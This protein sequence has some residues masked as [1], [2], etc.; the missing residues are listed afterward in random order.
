V[1]VWT[2]GYGVTRGVKAGMAITKDQAERLLVN[3]VQRFEP[4]LDRLVKVPLSQNQ[5]DALMSFVYN[6]LNAANLES[7]TLLSQKYYT[8][9]D[10]PFPR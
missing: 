9:A 10:Y 7:S 2:I 3:D 8:G 5:W 6:N 4:D 1:D